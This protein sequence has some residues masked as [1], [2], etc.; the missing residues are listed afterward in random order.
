MKSRLSTFLL[1]SMLVYLFPL[2]AQNIRISGVVN[3]DL[4]DPLPGASIVIKGAPIGVITDMDG[5]F[6]I[7][8]PVG[9]TLEIS[10]IGF[11]TQNIKISDNRRLKIEL[12]QD[13]VMLEEVVAIGYGGVKKSDLTGAVQSI[14]ADNLTM[15]SSVNAA[16]ML[17][18]RVTGLYV[19]S[20]NMDPG[21]VPTMT[22]RGQGSFAG[23]GDPLVIID[24][25]PMEGLGALNRLNPNDIVQM[26]VLKDASASAIYGA[27]GANGVIIVTTKT[28]REGKLKIEYAGKAYTQRPAK[29]A[30]VMNAEEYTRFFQD[31]AKDPSFA[32][33]YYKGFNGEEYYTYPVEYLY[34]GMITDTDWKN[35]VLNTNLNH[36]HNISISGGSKDFKYRAS[37]NYFDGNALVGP[38]DYRRFMFGTKLVYDNK[39]LYVNVDMN[40]TQELR[41]N[42][43]TNY[44]DALR[45]PP[46]TPVYDEDGELSKYPIE[47]MGW[48]HNPYYEK[49]LNKNN[50][51]ENSFRTF[52]SAKYNIIKGLYLEGRFGYDRRFNESFRDSQPYDPKDKNSAEIMTENWSNLLNDWVL[53]YAV[54]LGEHNISVITGSSYQKFRWRQLGARNTEIPLGISYYRIQDGMGT[55][56]SMYSGWT[57][58]AAQAFFARLNYDYNGKYL[59]TANFRADA[60]TQFGTK[61]KWGYFPSGALAWKIDREDFF[62]NSNPY[63][64]ILKIKAGWGMAGNSDV[65]SGRTQTLLTYSPATLGDGIINSVRWNSSYIAN[66]KLHWEKSTTTNVGLELGNSNYYFDLNY[67]IKKSSEL[68]IDR[69]MPHETGFSQ[70]TLN[71]GQMLN[72]GLEMRLDLFLDFFNKE[73]LWKPSI[74]FSLN[75]NEVLDM[76]SDE[77]LWNNLWYG[78]TKGHAGLRKADYPFKAMFGY[79]YDGIWSEEE[80]YVASVYGAKPGDPKFKDLNGYGTDGEIIKGRDGKLDEADKVYLGDGNPRY[81]GGFS[82][83]LRYKSIELNF[84]IE[85]VLDKKV[86][87]LNR[88]T[89]LG[90]EF[91][92]YGNLSREALNRW[93]PD[94]QNTD[95]PSLTRTTDPKLFISDFCI[96]DASFLRMR[97]LTLSYIVPLPKEFFIEELRFF[98]SITNLFTITKYKG[99]NPDVM[100][101]DSRYNM[102]P[103]TR[104]ITFGLNVSL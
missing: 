35:E 31:L 92:W 88:I 18:G 104:T 49:I 94:N 86:A 98:S 7:E 67:Y 48:M 76:D 83:T 72:K 93:T 64:N 56:Y 68:L 51:E 11:A 70:I 77:I 9:T 60:A 102:N 100:D 74:W 27:K 97:D 14:R 28:G 85:A 16:Q 43:K 89:M 47:S 75:N 2:Y 38:A 46:V 3:D 25:F 53:N 17:Q 57:E 61:S 8:A 40:Y 4:G 69:Q 10:F 15:S 22:L 20:A 91:E 36:E 59:V 58:R 1:F 87:N 44:Y 78:D 54:L 96:Q 13:Y 79:I 84:M 55:S 33:S 19:N 30:E 26:D 62:D 90:P 24:G 32:H 12:K 80:R 37:G 50:S 65:P 21:S 34:N 42:I 71:K 95:I 103:F 101:I 81:L 82:N 5:N 23:S 52:M 29:Q 66:P 45:F 6:S 99:V 73:L 41:N 63:V 39:K